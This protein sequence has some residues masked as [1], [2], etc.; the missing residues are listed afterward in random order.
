MCDL[1]SNPRCCQ[2]LK[3]LTFILIISVLFEYSASLAFHAN[4]CKILG[5]AP[6]CTN[7]YENTPFEPLS[8]N[9]G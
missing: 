1:I 5:L 4:F 2:L 6:K 7:G 9:V 8:V 3:F